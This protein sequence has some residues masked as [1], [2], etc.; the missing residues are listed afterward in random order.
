MNLIF[1]ILFI[2][3]SVFKTFRKLQSVQTGFEAYPAYSADTAGSFPRGKV[4]RA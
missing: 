1:Y 4:A 2:Q 3:N